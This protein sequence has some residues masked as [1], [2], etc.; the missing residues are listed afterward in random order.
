MNTVKIDSKAVRM[1]AHRGLSGLERENTCA[2]FVAAGNRAAYFGIETDVHSTSDGKFVIFHDDNTERVG[3]D[4]LE[5]E[6]TTFETLRRLQLTDLD[7]KRGRTDLVIPTLEE[8]IRICQKYEKYCILELKSEFRPTEVKKI[9][10]LIDRIGYLDHVIFISFYLSDLIALR[11]YLPDQPAQYLLGE[12]SDE[13][14]S[15]MKEYR[16]DL[17]IWYRSLSREIVDQVHNAG[18]LVNAWTVDE[19]EAAEKLIDMGV[20][21]LTSNILE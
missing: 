12:W 6:K 7:G 2:A 17:D 1:I 10:S 20:D 8:Y 11:R 21:F 19:K 18:L 9:I 16:L 13:A 14:F 15:A 5:I 4:R 3:I